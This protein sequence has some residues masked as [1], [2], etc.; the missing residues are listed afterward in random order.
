MTNLSQ[1]KTFVCFSM[2][3]SFFFNIV[4]VLD[5]PYLQLKKPFLAFLLKRIYSVSY[6][7]A[8]CFEQSYLD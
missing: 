3:A 2:I 5:V 1:A 6:L 7:C 8:N 4:S